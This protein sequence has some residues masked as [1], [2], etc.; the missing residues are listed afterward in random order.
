MGTTKDATS[1]Y[2]EGVLLSHETILQVS[3]RKTKF[4]WQHFVWKA[5]KVLFSS[6]V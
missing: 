6:K 3:L 4:H 5:S 2:R 1:Y